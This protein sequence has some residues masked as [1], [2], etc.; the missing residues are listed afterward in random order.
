MSVR[1]NAVTIA[2]LLPAWEAHAVSVGLE[3]TTRVRAVLMDE[4]EEVAGH[5]AKRGGGSYMAEVPEPG[6]WLWDQ[7][8]HGLV[9]RLTAEGVAAAE[10]LDPPSGFDGCAPSEWTVSKTD[11]AVTR[12]W[13]LVLGSG[14][15]KTSVTESVSV[16]GEI[17][18]GTPAIQIPRVGCKPEQVADLIADLELA[19]QLGVAL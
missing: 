4:V 18:R 1:E 12:I 13:S 14:G 2:E 16:D 15:V 5:F 19:R 7:R 11:L 3:L 10:Q 17:V 6:S 8:R 9:R